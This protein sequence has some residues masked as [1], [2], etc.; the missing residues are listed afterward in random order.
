MRVT[1]LIREYVEKKV[2]EAYPKSEA[3]LIW[4]EKS[5]RA[6]EALTR[7]NDV[8]EAYAKKVAEE[9][10][11]EF[12]LGDYHLKPYDGRNWFGTSWYGDCEEY[13][14]S[15]KAEDERRKKIA[16]T[17]E[18]ILISLELGGTRAD[19]DEMLAKIGK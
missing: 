11:A 15:R 9:F 19:L 7:A 18:E 3:E 13:Q 1:K 6:N 16:E 8:V 10:N 17:V 4:E 2:R 12:G 14:A 5:R